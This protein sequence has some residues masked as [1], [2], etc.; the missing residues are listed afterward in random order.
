MA[1]TG[2]DPLRRSFRGRVAHRTITFAAGCYEPAGRSGCAPVA[3]VSCAT[4]SVM[5]EAVG[6]LADFDIKHG[7]RS[8]P[9]PRFKGFL[10][11]VQELHKRLTID[12]KLSFL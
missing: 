2:N 8:D 4:W 7:V 9:V 11:K 6:I 5:P 1:P 10:Q 3:M 12:P